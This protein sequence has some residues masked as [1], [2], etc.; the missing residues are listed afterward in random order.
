MV[1]KKDYKTGTDDEKKASWETFIKKGP[2]KV[3]KT[4]VVHENHADLEKTINKD[5]PIIK[6]MM[7][8]NK[9]ATAYDTDPKKNKFKKDLYGNPEKAGES[10]GPDKPKL[11]QYLFDKKIENIRQASEAW[12]KEE[13][14]PKSGNGDTEESHSW[15]VPSKNNI[16]RPT[17][18]YGLILLAIIGLAAVIFWEKISNWWNGPAEEAGEVGED[19]KEEEENEKKKG[20]SGQ[21]RKK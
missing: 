4:I 2:E 14:T 18:S 9:S 13:P 12:E 1:K 11:I 15:W 5:H 20:R 7:E 8:T 3:I 16:W 17:V 6:D 10:E 21:E 19:K